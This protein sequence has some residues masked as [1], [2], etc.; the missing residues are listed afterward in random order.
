MSV[1]RRPDNDLN[2]DN[3]DEEEEPV[4]VGVFE[5]ATEDELKTRIIK[6]AKRRLGSSSDGPSKSIFSTFQGFG[7]TSTASN[8][9]PSKP[10]SQ[11][12]NTGTGNSNA[13]AST[14]SGTSIFGGAKQTFN[15]GSGSSTATDT[16]PNSNGSSSPFKINTTTPAKEITATQEKSPEFCTKLK[17]LNNAVLDCIKEHIVSG[18]LCILT[19]IFE[20]Y[21]KY[22]ENIETNDKKSTSVEPKKTIG[23]LEDTA[24]KSSS[25]VFA[26]AATFGGDAPKKP[27][28]IFA[29]SVPAEP[30]ISNDNKP[31]FTFSKPFA[32][33]SGSPAASSSSTSFTAGTEASST[34]P[35]PFFSFSQTAKTD[36]PSTSSQNKSEN[37]ND[38]TEENEEPPKNEFTAVVEEDSIYSKRCKVFVKTNDDYTTRGTGTLYLKSVQNGKTQMIVR[39]DTNLG[40]ILLNV[41]LG[42]GIP[43]KRM[44]KNNVMLVCIPTPEEGPK[45]SSVL[46]RVKTSDDADELHAEITKYSK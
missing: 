34:I 3:W 36:S 1:K 23:S 9:T 7:S 14:S 35:K 46:L 20:D 31:M 27:N 30:A 8:N 29:T 24:K 40:N 25:S 42:A 5:K 39:A 37:A 22:I 16:L 33:F 17:D 21:I 26:P 18:K 32:S 28:S 4:A 11:L 6:T 38:V 2:H 43:A 13:T 15:F 12:S 41:L 10:F 44:G 19:P 45:P